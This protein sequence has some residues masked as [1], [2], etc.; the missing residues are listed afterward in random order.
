M[1]LQLETEAEMDSNRPSDGELDKKIKAAKAALKAQSGIYANL[2]KAVGEL[3]AL[4][5]ESPSQIWKLILEL[6][7]EINP[8][9]YVGGKPPQRSYER[10]IKNRELFA[11]CWESKKMGKKMYIKFALKENRYYYVSLHRSKGL[12]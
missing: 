8:T 6:L 3:N 2:S 10:S 9:D 12:P 5:I 11:F 4:D 1:M 7:E